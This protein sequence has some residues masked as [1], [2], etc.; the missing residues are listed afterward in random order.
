MIVAKPVQW[1]PCWRVIPARYAEDLV[2]HKISDPEDYSIISDLEQ[3]TNDRVR[4]DKGEIPSF[5]HGDLPKGVGADLI[6]AAFSNRTLSRFSDATYGVCYVAHDLGTAIEETR[7]KR[8]EFM[9]HTKQPAMELKMR[10]LKAELDSHLHDIRGMQKTLPEVYN[11]TSYGD[12]QA[13]GKQL[14]GEG[15]E[16]IVYDSVRHDK[17][18]CA[19]IFRPATL[20]NCRRDKG[21]V[22]QWDGTKIDKVLELKDYG[23]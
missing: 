8:A 10:V 11:K 16:G 4:M 17:G 19:A 23:G 20:R 13:F 9:S 21:L 2:F 14:H 18:Q 22:Y 3:L 12:S 5:P 1:D 7:H 6:M 15:S